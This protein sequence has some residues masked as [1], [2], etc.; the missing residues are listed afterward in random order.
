MAEVWSLLRI[1]A[2]GVGMT[3]VRKKFSLPRRRDPRLAPKQR[4]RTWGTGFQ[5]TLAQRTRKAGASQGRSETLTIAGVR[6][7]RA[8]WLRGRRLGG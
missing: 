3:S 1:E 8:G 5:R 6:E 2:P 7:S 4:A